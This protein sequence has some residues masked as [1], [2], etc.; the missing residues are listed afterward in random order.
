MINYDLVIKNMYTNSRKIIINQCPDTDKLTME[1]FVGPVN[2][3]C[4]A[5]E[6]QVTVI[7]RLSDYVI[8]KNNKNQ[9]LYICKNCIY[10]YLIDSNINFDFYYVVSININRPQQLKLCIWG[11][12]FWN[13]TEI[14]RVINR[15][16]TIKQSTF[17]LNLDRTFGFTF[18]KYKEIYEILL[19]KMSIIYVLPIMEYL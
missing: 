16:Y 14:V 2:M 13:R 5:C 9:R 7:R 10:P 15:H 8:G 3:A 12:A 18:E 6:R 19:K 1:D 17:N 11:N 4:D